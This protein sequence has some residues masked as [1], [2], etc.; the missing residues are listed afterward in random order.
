MVK[1]AMCNA[2]WESVYLRASNER[3]KVDVSQGPPKEARGV[4]GSRST[5]VQP[6]PAPQWELDR[7]GLLIPPRPGGHAAGG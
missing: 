4:F 1:M 3:A 5:V 6:G 7:F 2:E